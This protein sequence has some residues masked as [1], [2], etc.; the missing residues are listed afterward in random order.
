VNYNNSVDQNP[1]NQASVGP[2]YIAPMD[3]APG[4]TTIH[5][6]GLLTRLD[7]TGNLTASRTI[8]FATPNVAT[9]ADIWLPGDTVFIQVPA[10]TGSGFTLTVLDIAGNPITV[11]PALSANGGMFVYGAGS[12]PGM[13]GPEAPVDFG[14]VLPGA[15]TAAAAPTSGVLAQG[16]ALTLYALTAG[17]YRLPPG[18]AP[19]SD[20]ANA[21]LGRG[22]T[23]PSAYSIGHYALTFIGSSLNIAGQAIQ[24]QVWIN[25]SLAAAATPEPATAGLH[26]VTVDISS[27]PIPG[28]AGDIIALSVDVSG[29]LTATPTNLSM[30]A[31]P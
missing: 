18:E 31:G 10:H 4:N 21:D 11:W 24:A 9:G 28:H 7:L 15:G 29:N 25:G 14:A 6:T 1:P 3:G 17:V 8:Q 30:S 2:N 20:S 16:A 12:A 13:A 5:R 23:M 22:T 26:T 27:A 19:V